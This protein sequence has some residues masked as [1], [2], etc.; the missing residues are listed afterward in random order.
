[1]QQ[2]WKVEMRC[3]GIVIH[4][5]EHTKFKIQTLENFYVRAIEKYWHF[6]IFSSRPYI[7]LE[8][9][10]FAFLVCKVGIVG[11]LANN[12]SFVSKSH[13]NSK[14]YGIISI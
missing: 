10:V 6:I 3:I 12:F 4:Q 14:F 1:M 11:L 8:S 5:N 13:W 9:P 2:H 7:G